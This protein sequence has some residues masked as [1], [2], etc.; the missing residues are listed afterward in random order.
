LTVFEYSAFVL[1]RRINME[2]CS[3]LR[4]VTLA[5]IAYCIGL[6]AVEIPNALSVAHKS[7]DSVS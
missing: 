7:R 2:Y 5:I 6:I 3:R 1:I 4:G